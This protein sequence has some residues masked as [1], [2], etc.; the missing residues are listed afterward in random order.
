MVETR[1]IDVKGRLRH[2]PQGQKPHQEAA[3]EYNK[4][5]ERDKGPPDPGIMRL[6]QLF[7]LIHKDYWLK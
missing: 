6:D 2:R 4:L 3:N 7:W 5:C 1:Q